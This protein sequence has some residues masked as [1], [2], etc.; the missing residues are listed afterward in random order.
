MLLT[1]PPLNPKANREKMIQIMFETF[2]V[3]ATYVA[4]Q[5]M[6]ALYAS[7]RGSGVIVDSGD[8]VT[9]VMPIYEG[10]LISHAVQR[11]DLAGRDLTNYLVELLSEEGHSFATTAKHEIARDMKEKLCY[12]A[13][14]FEKEM[15]LELQVANKTAN[16]ELPD[17]QVITIGSE[18]FCCPEALFQPS[19]LGME[20]PG[21]HKIIYDTI[22][23]CDIDVRRD[24][25]PNIIIS[26]GS[27]M[28]PGFVDR[29]RSEIGK[30]IPRSYH[31]KVV[32]P[33]ERKYS[34]WIGGSI[35]ASLST[36]QRR[37]IT[38]QDYNE[39]GPSVVNSK[40]YLLHNQV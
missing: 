6:L 29:L 8:G 24:M 19:L 5:P 32:A 13:L 14:D 4:M 28:F 27:T 3:P 9:H 38:K 26:G 30:H 37:W 35:L 7:G 25:Y 21:I 2:N 18:R 10:H 1:Q 17:G 33:P 15:K 11:L 20:S 16:Y 36:F 12:T 22:T 40:C 39:C 34:V 23:K 31:I